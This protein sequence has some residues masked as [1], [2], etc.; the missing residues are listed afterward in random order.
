MDKTRM[1]QGHML[2]IAVIANGLVVNVDV[3]S[4]IA[5]IDKWYFD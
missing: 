1:G 5:A 3:T 4:D 2:T